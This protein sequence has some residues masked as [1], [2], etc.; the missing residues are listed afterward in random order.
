MCSL[1]R[2]YNEETCFL[3]IEIDSHGK[4]VL[5][6]ISNYYNTNFFIRGINLNKNLLERELDKY[7]L[8]TTF[9]GSAFDLPKLKKELDVE[10]NLP[11]LDLKPLC[12]NLNLKGGL[13]KVEKILNLKRPSHLY[14]NPVNLWKTFHASGDRE[15][16][17]LLI[18]YNREDIENLKFIADHI[19]KKMSEKLYKQINLPSN[20]A[21]KS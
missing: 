10:I 2:K 12:V 9:N 6:G 14:G 20:Y 19:Y 15:Y 7:K 11:H 4:I 3:D 17:D 16:L 13:K 18:E 5:V 21:G 1:Y 8:I